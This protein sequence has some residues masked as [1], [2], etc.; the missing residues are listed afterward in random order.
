MLVRIAEIT[1]PQRMIRKTELLLEKRPDD[2]VVLFYHGSA[3]ERNGQYAQAD[4]VFTHLLSLRP[5]APRA[6]LAK[7][8]LAMTMGNRDQAMPLYGR[9]VQ[10]GGVSADVAQQ[11]L[12]KLGISATGS[13]DKMSAGTQ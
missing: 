9:L 1:T 11:D 2:P 4:Q 12:R 10:L 5:G 7:A 3:Y 6:I 13:G 8:R